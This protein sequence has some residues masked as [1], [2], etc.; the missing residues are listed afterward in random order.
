[1]RPTG[2]AMYLRHTTVKKNGKE[3]VYWRL[4]R[5]VRTGG[6]VR[7]E[8][9]AHLGEL[10]AEGRATA[11][12]LAEEFLGRRSARQRELFEAPPES[13]SRPLKVHI[14]R[15]RVEHSRSFGEV[16]L[17]WK[18]WQALG[19]DE[20]CRTVM[21][22]GKEKV[23]WADIAAILVLARLCEPSSELHIAEDW[24]RRSALEEILGVPSEVVHHTRLYQGLDQLL[25]HKRAL[26]EH[27]K[28]RYGKLFGVTYDLLLY[29]VTSTYF[30]G[31]ADRNDLA[32]QGHSRDHRSDCKQV[33]IGLV[34]T[35]EGYPLG[36][37][38]FAGNR[39]DVTTVE[40]VVEAMEVRYGKADRV[41]VMDRGMV[42]ENNLSTLR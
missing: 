32:L 1:M 2:R 22:V 15:V 27:L 37:E 3:H 21:P 24:Y 16:W 5:S 31:E 25:P 42:S 36:Y 34:V 6:K 12:A 18:V 4:V 17:A 41:W 9:V 20:F 38:V 14:D 30:E 28:E 33:C 35:R 26:E 40:E 39:T 11:R 23:P 19:L 29:D 7:Q 8:T 13:R 10:D